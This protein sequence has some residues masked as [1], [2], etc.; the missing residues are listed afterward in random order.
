MVGS[1]GMVLGKR[2]QAR[3]PLIN[4]EITYER[5]PSKSKQGETVFK[6]TGA[7]VSVKK[8]EA[9]GPFAVAKT[10]QLS[11]NSTVILL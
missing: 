6:Q 4:Y 1:P 8:E 11:L 3:Q 7:K 2:N 10:L 9:S 5:Q